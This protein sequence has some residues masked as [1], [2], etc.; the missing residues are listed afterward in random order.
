MAFAS[1]C[2][3]PAPQQDFEFFFAPDECSQSDRVQRLKAAFHRTRPQCRPGPDW[4]RDTLEFFGA[5]I[6]K[7]EKI[8][9]KPSRTFGNNHGVRL[10]DT[11]QARGQVRR[12]ADNRLFLSRPRSDEVADHD[13]PSRNADTGLQRSTRL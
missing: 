10:C 11:L 5:E 3:G 7:L 12:L 6:I 13:Q 4:S 1:L 2:S 9:E 8:A